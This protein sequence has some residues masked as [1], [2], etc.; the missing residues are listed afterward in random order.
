MLPL[1]C[2]ARGAKLLPLSTVGFTQFVS[3]TI[4]F[5]LGLFVFGEAF[6]ARYFIA[7]L[8]IWTA[9]ILYVISLKF[10]PK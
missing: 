4:Q 9:V 2:F 7:F 1:Y 3:P 6:P 8:F 5:A 10:A